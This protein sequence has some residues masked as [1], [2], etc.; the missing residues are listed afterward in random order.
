MLN[1]IA[2]VEGDRLPFETGESTPNTSRRSVLFPATG[3]Q[4]EDDND[5]LLPVLY[6]QF[7]VF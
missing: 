1:Y 5:P 3:N 4:T 6:R 2:F 7:F